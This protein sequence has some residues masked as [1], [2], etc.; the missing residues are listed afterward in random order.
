MT[1]IDGG[2]GVLSL[3]VALGADDDFS[4]S[5]PL[6]IITFTVNYNIMTLFLYDYI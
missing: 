1:T 4:L 5:F 3:N 2:R 6:N